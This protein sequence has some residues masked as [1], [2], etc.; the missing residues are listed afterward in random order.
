MTALRKLRALVLLFAFAVL[1]AGG[2]T[3]MTAGSADASRWPCCWVMVCPVLDP[4]P[5]WEICVPCPIFPP[6]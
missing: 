6:P 2:F 5:C 1:F 3:V 4:G